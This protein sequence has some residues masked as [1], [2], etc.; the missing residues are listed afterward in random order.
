MEAITRDSRIALDHLVR[1]AAWTDDPERRTEIITVT[2]N[3]SKTWLA[4]FTVIY[5]GRLAHLLTNLQV[6]IRIPV[7]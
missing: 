5:F 3:F 1:S 4:V 6:G 2:V 7:S